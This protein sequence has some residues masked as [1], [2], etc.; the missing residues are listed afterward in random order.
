MVRS[1][2]TDGH[3]SNQDGRGRERAAE[4]EIGSDEVNFKQHLFQIPGDSDLGNRIRQLA[5]LNPEPG[6]ARGI[7]ARD[8]VR[9][10]ANQLGH[11]EAVANSGDDF[12]RRALAWLDK[13]VTGADAGVAGDPSRGVAGGLEA[14][15]SRR[16]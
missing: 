5:V 7:V 11:V 13:K 3:L 9:A 15:L 1:L 16:V 12:R 14:E 6:G 8:G 2:A 4:I 10:S